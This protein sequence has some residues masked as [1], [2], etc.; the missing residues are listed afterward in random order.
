MGLGASRSENGGRVNAASS[1]TLLAL[2][3]SIVV[4]VVSLSNFLD[5]R[6]FGFESIRAQQR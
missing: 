5:S 1:G 2:T 6:Y 4:D 3:A